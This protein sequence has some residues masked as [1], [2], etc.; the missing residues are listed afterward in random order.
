MGPWLWHSALPLLVLDPRPPGV[1]GSPSLPPPAEGPPR[2]LARGQLV[3]CR[4]SLGAC[5]GRVGPEGSS[6]A[7]HGGAGR[8][9]CSRCPQEGLTQSLVGR[10]HKP[11]EPRHPRWQEVV[12]A[13]A[14]AEPLGSLC[15][16]P[17]G[18]AGASVAQIPGANEEGARL[19][20]REV[21]HGPVFVPRCESSTGASVALLSW[22]PAPTSTEHCRVQCCGVLIC[23][24]GGPYGMWRGGELGQG[25]PELHRARLGHSTPLPGVI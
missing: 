17:H 20:G 7:S 18:T 21:W 12:C 25:V 8:G 24:S 22:H 11:P 2:S 5:W 1:R 19:A 6:V 23:C 3:Q 13:W 14:G 9:C 16:F 4:G 10:K 15:R